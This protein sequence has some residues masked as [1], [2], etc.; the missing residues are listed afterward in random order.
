MLVKILKVLSF[1]SLLLP[2]SAA[3]GAEEAVVHL[4]LNEET[5][6]TK[7]DGLNVRLMA[8]LTDQQQTER[9]FMRTPRVWM[10]CYDGGRQ[11]LSIDTADDLD[12]WPS[13]TGNREIEVAATLRSQ[14]GSFPELA[15]ALRGFRLS[16]LL[17]ISID[18]T[19]RAEDILRSWLQGFPIK[20]TAAPGGDLKDLNL[21]I[22]PE[23]R[24]SK[25]RTEASTVVSGCELLA[26]R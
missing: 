17:S 10:N 18:V 24:S 6:E 9:E 7:F 25:F 23:A 13:V 12:P 21:V 8:E 15:T 14:T 3:A 11:I 19:G 22:F 5:A 2:P 16:G 4:F 26:R 20:I 1:A